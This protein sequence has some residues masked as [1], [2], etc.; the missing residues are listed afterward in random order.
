MDFVDG[1]QVKIERQIRREIGLRAQ[2]ELIVGVVAAATLYR[3]D[4]IAGGVVDGPR[5]S[6]RLPRALGGAVR[7]LSRPR[8]IA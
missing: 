2:E 7:N 1:A 4:Y 8:P 6:E 3:H 5:E